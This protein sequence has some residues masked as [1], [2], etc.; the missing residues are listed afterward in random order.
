M[1]SKALEIRIELIVL[2]QLITFLCIGLIGAFLAPLLYSFL[3]KITQAPL[4]AFIIT[5]AIC[6]GTPLYKYSAMYYGHVLVAL[7]LFVVFFLW[8]NMKDK[9]PINPVKVLISGYFL[10]FAIITEY[11]TAIIA[12]L[13]GLYILYVLWEKKH[14]FD[15]KIYIHLMLGVLPPLIIALAYNY[16]VFH[17]PFKTGYS[18]EIVDQFLVGQSTG[19][20]G[21]GMPNL[22]VLFYMTLHPTM[23]IFWQSPFLLFAFIGWFQMWKNRQYRAEA[24]LSL[25]II[26]IYSLMMSGYYI[27]WGGAAT[28]PRNLLPIF[29]FFCIPL[30][31]ITKKWEKWILLIF[32]LVS[33]AQIFVLTGGQEGELIKKV[34]EM[35]PSTSIKTMFQ[36]PTILYHVYLPEFLKQNMG[37]NRGHQFLHLQ[38][39]ASL[40]PLAVIEAALLALFLKI[41]LT[42]KQ[43]SAQPISEGMPNAND[44]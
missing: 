9:E 33:I 7:F 12:F 28:T 34:Y 4:Y 24:L 20:M 39:F 30:A 22:S 6:L 31:F 35:L 1:I 23:G 15:K 14:L 38:G 36:R 37:E 13:L 27:W 17:D 11:P 43:P 29:P 5:L 19:M 10:G 41:A 8:F 21:I 25:G 2:T 44:R 26:L 16:A 40:I 3:K 18:Y 42:P 32:V